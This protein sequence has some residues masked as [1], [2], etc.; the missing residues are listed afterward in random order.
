MSIVL[1]E[2][3]E[4][5]I[6]AWIEALESDRA[7]SIANE[8]AIARIGLPYPIAGAGKHRIVFDAGEGLVL[9]VAKVPK[10]VAC[11]GN[12]VWLYDRSPPELRRHLCD[13]VDF[14]Y[15][16]VV[17]KK[18]TARVPFR[19]RYVEQL[20]RICEEFLAAG[21]VIRDLY[22]RRRN[23]PRKKNIRLDEKRDKVVLI[24]YA[25]VHIAIGSPGEA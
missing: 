21:I 18:M 9:K 23:R 13:I 2:A 6:R 17:M 12:E 24:D 16:W 5:R 14:G 4:E 19:D 1:T 25:N 20:D 22:T 7:G 8:E 10:G 3:D 15:G 11:N